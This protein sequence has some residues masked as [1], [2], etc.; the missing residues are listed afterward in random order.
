MANCCFIG[1]TVIYK[2]QVAAR[3]AF[4]HFSA[5]VERTNKAIPITGQC[6]LLG[7]SVKYHEPVKLKGPGLSFNGW[8][9][10]G[11]ENYAAYFFLEMLQEFGTVESL[12][13]DYEELM[14]GVY[15]QYHYDSDSDTLT[16]FYV[17]Y[18]HTPDYPEFKTPEE[19]EAFFENGDNVKLWDNALQKSGVHVVITKEDC[20]KQYE[21]FEKKKMEA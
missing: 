17:P 7:V 2:E 21:E 5:V 18:N 6:W 14:N 9:K 3:K 16:D 11:L 20:L 10:W 19:E 12:D 8:V 13:V 15:G 1:A 4:E